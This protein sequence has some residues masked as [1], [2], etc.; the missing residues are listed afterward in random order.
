[1]HPIQSASYRV[2]LKPSGIVILCASPGIEQGNTNIIM[3]EGLWWTETSA[4][5]DWPRRRNNACP[6]GLATFPIRGCPEPRRTQSHDP[7][8]ALPLVSNPDGE[9]HRAQIY[10]LD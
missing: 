8:L 7:I 3:Q 10:R 1:M 6:I 2:I 9:I 5:S 4:A